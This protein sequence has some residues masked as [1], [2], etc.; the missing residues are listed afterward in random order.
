MSNKTLATISI[1]LFIFFFFKTPN[2]IQEKNKLLKN[3]S[4]YLKNLKPAENDTINRGLSSEEE[5]ICLP[6]SP[7]LLRLQKEI[8]E[9]ELERNKLVNVSYKKKFWRN[10]ELSSLSPSMAQALVKNDHLISKE[11]KIDDCTDLICVINTIYKD[12]GQLTGHLFYWFYL[13]TG[14]FITMSRD[15]PYLIIPSDEKLEKILFQK[16]ELDFIWAVGQSLPPHMT[17]LPTM[18]TI[19]RSP[20]HPG[21]KLLQKEDNQ[22]F[23]SAAMAY[24]T[25]WIFFVDNC[26]EKKFSW[27]KEE[28]LDL[29]SRAVE[30]FYHELTHH[31]DYSLGNLHKNVDQRP[32]LSVDWM[33]LSNWKK[34]EERNNNKIIYRWAGDSTVNYISNYSQTSPHEDYAESWTFSRLKPEDSLIK[35]PEKFNYFKKIFGISYESDGQSQQYINFINKYATKRASQLVSNCSLSTNHNETTGPDYQ[36]CVEKVKEEEGDLIIK[37]IKDQY[38]ES[39]QFLSS[40][41]NKKS[42]ADYSNN[43]IGEEMNKVLSLNPDLKKSLL[44]SKKLREAI[45]QSMD[46][47]AL[48][49]YCSNLF[50]HSTTKLEECFNSTAQEQ[51]VLLSEEIQSEVAPEIVSYEIDRYL[52]LNPFI[53]AKNNT[54]QLVKKHLISLDFS[55]PQKIDELIKNCMSKENRQAYELFS[56]YSGKEQFIEKGLLGCIN[57]KAP[58]L[59]RDMISITLDAEKNQ[60]QEYHLKYYF[61]NF[62][63]SFLQDI[64]TQIQSRASSELFWMNQEFD[65]IRDSVLITLKNKYEGDPEKAINSCLKDSD[66]LPILEKIISQKHPQ[67]ILNFHTLAEW[68]LKVLKELCSGIV[69]LTSKSSEVNAEKLQLNKNLDI[70]FLTLQLIQDLFNNPDPGQIALI[71]KCSMLFSNNFFTKN[72]ESTNEYNNCKDNSVSELQKLKIPSCQAELKGKSICKDSLRKIQNEIFNSSSLDYFKKSFLNMVSNSGPEAKNII[73]RCNQNK[74]YEIESRNEAVFIKNIIDSEVGKNNFQN[75]CAANALAQFSGSLYD[76]L[77]MINRAVFATLEMKKELGTLDNKKKWEITRA[78]LH[79]RTKL[80]MKNKKLKN[81][82]ACIQQ[83]NNI[84]VEL[85]RYFEMSWEMDWFEINSTMKSISSEKETIIADFLAGKL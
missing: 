20:I 21:Y 12:E 47:D 4:L 48:I 8:K 39:C 41:H 64:H 68:N 84:E 70:K 58:P 22:I 18:K 79:L 32:S 63:P 16:E 11:I 43:K 77:S 62:L 80:I 54:A 5:Q 82:L 40:D 42:L 75:L 13:K 36:R 57:T 29:G 72:L 66:L 60:L 15:H 59:I 30:C 81:R 71:N 35:I 45:S 23:T 27:Q 65:S 78:N 34:V 10:L 76:K 38:W 31:I 17:F 25:G 14:Y 44:A 46:S 49:M 7:N 3:S 56:P 50:G 26:L 2:H 69:P 74:A 19:Y 61:N 55:L 73:I 28:L 6:H 51:I 24:S 52:K 53:E 1:L 33:K 83:W 9:L 67:S 85:R 37:L